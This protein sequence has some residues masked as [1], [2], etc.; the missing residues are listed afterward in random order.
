MSDDGLRQGMPL[1]Q[2]RLSN[3]FLNYMFFPKPLNPIASLADVM[4]ERRNTESKK[5]SASKS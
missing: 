2:R 5:Q 1:R 3:Y 4:L